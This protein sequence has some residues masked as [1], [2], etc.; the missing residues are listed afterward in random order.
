LAGLNTLG[1]EAAVKAIEAQSGE[2]AAA[3]RQL[4]LSL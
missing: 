3:E 4:E 2:T 1:M